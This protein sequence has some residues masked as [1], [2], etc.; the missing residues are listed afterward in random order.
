MLAVQFLNSESERKYSVILF[1]ILFLVIKPELGFTQEVFSSFIIL[2][3][4]P[5]ENP[6]W[7]E[8]FSGGQEGESLLHTA[9]IINS[10]KEIFSQEVY[11]KIKSKL[12]SENRITFRNLNAIGIDTN[13][14]LNSLNLGLTVNIKD[15]KLTK[16]LISS[17]RKKEDIKDLKT[18]QNFSG[19]VN[20]RSSAEFLGNNFSSGSGYSYNTST[21]TSLEG[22]LN[23]KG[24]VFETQYIH[25]EN[26]AD[27]TKQSR[28]AYTRF[29]HDNQRKAIRYTLGDI[30]E[31]SRGFQE[32]GF[33]TGFNMR[34]ELTI[35]PN[36]FRSSFKRHKFFL[37]TDSRVE[38]FIN[39]RLSKK[40]YLKQGPV[41]LS[42][43]P[44]VSGE[45]DVRIQITDV[46]G[47]IKNLNYA[48]LNDS[49]LLP[50]G[51][52]DYSYTLMFPR[53]QDDV[54]KVGFDDSVYN[55][56]D[57]SFNGYYHYGAFIDGVL[58]LDWQISKNRFLVG[59]EAIY[60]QKEGIARINVAQSGNQDLNLDG[61]AVRVE[62]EN[63]LFKDS[64]LS[65]FRFNSG[66]EYRT[67]GFTTLSS[68][69]ESDTEFIASM[70]VGQNFKNS[71]RGSL[72]FAKEWGYTAAGDQDFI[73]SNFG[74]TFF[75][76][77]DFSANIRFNLNDRDDS[78]VLFSLNWYAPSNDQ[79]STTT[80][81]PINKVVNT[82]FVTFP[83]KN[84]QNFRTYVGGETNDLS[85]RA[86]FGIDYFNQR[87][88][89]RLAHSSAFID[90]SGQI[91][92][93]QLSFG[94]GIAFTSRGFALTRPVDDAFV[95]VAMPDRPKGH[96]VPI[97]KGIDSQRGEINRF[98]PAS[99]TNLAAYYTDN[100]NLD[101][102]QLP[103]GYSL[104][105]ETYSFYPTY[106]SGIY[107]KVDVDGEVS[108]NGVA[109][110]ENQEPAAYLTG[111]VYLMNEDGSRGE[112]VGQFFN[113]GDGAF[114]IERLE[115]R[116]YIV[117]FEEDD[118]E[119]QEIVVEVNK[120]IGVQ[121][122]KEP[123]I[124]KKR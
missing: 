5:L 42:D 17:R 23:V 86:L 43:F 56:S 14:D 114:S 98:G 80:Y 41:E 82:E 106:K 48:D 2:N 19:F 74:W 46:F 76:N 88:E 51:F 68:D 67:K 87:A 119:Y 65:D 36:L 75:K 69:S 93:T 61:S 81:D 64:S 92:S 10:M 95:L 18:L 58:G 101:I 112:V 100:I 3:K 21:T 124:I 118:T 71:V 33:G 27:G 120:S 47:N 39:G 99:I 4:Q 55:Y 38:V 45:N 73:T 22:V 9:E 13:M 91:Q 78:T 104:K 30:D 15:K 85:K 59:A 62:Y 96:N 20:L 72:G 107:I 121:E 84:R 32:I 116:K 8:Y 1:L 29:V 11:E 90:S 108:I 34:K 70:S 102:S 123:V 49:R 52:S 25:N 54:F 97:G 31:T 7:V 60:G 6:A 113:G 89:Y 111:S 40:L 37:E 105:K 66:F 44:F 94:T 24:V 110:Y 109:L 63:L 79:Q 12:D 57:P 26:E 77:F 50:V 115:K 28:R 53:R 103:Y 122:I 16:V 35:Q 117:V 83:I